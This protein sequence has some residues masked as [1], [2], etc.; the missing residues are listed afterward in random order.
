MPGERHK[1]WPGA[2]A[3]GACVQW[4]ALLSSLLAAS[5]VRAQGGMTV[6][7][8]SWLDSARDRELPLR[9]RWPAGGEIF[10]G[11]RC[12]VD[13]TA[14]RRR[15]PPLSRRHRLARRRPARQGSRGWRRMARQGLRRIAAR[16]ARLAVD[17]WR[18]PHELCR[19]CAG[20]DSRFGRE[21]PARCRCDAARAGVAVHGG[22][23]HQH[24]VAAL[25]GRRQ[26]RAND[27]EWSH[28]AGPGERWR[29]D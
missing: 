28:G 4:R 11:P 25:A 1:G 15:D 21:R 9:I 12:P 7:D 2:D 27:K 10:T 14:V 19:P 26:V 16:P 22:P 17:R 8:F 18:R 6:S 20:A 24:L 5:G 3:S 29:F 13:R 23:S